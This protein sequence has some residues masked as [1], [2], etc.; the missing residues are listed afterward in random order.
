[1]LCSA[2]R[3]GFGNTT[4]TKESKK[5]EV[6]R[7]KL[8]VGVIAAFLVSAADGHTTGYLEVSGGKIYYEEGGSGPAIV[9]LHDGLMSS[10][11]W[12][13]VWQPLAA[14]CRVIRY[15]RRGYGRSDPARSSFSP[16]EDLAKLLR[17]LK[18]E[19]TVIVGSS[20]GGALAIDFAISHPEMV[21]GLFLIGPVVHGMEYS[22]EFRARANRNN[23][24]MERD[25]VRAM[26]SNWSQDQFLIPGTSQTARRKVYDELVANGAKLK[27]YDPNLGEKLS[28]AAS[29]RLGEIKARAV[30]LVG[31]AD[32][33]DVHTHCAAIKAG[34]PASELIVV[35][36]ARH[37]IQV[38]QPDEVVKRLMKFAEQTARK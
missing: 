17:H 13:E 1:V 22:A 16:V 14:K 2:I 20:A 37:L 25:D 32:I 31:K 29:T 38:E 19:R 7:G 21:N 23:E 27:N 28:P 11:T 4:R 34:I 10:V 15:D 3:T 24:P 18:V 12:D 8:F 9:L 35:D 33:A 36:G 5:E 26:A 6:R 30:I